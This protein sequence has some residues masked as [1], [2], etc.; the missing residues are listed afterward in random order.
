V[1]WDLLT[2]F[3]PRP[4]PQIGGLAYLINEVKIKAT[5]RFL[6]QKDIICTVV[7]V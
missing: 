1:N 4:T 2:A 6:K 7:K 3:G 5:I